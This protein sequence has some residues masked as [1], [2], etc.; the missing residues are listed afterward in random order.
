MSDNEFKPYIRHANY[1]ETD[2]M[3]IIHHSNYIRWMEEA[4]LDVMKQADISYKELE[5]MG[6][7]IPVLSVT[8]QYKNMV[9]FDDT[10]AITVKTIKYTGVKF[11]L[12]Y[13]FKD[14]E[15]DK[16]YTTG[17]SSH[18]FLDKNYR[19]FSLKRNYP[20]LHEKFERMLV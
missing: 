4:R 8:C 7:I 9:H 19:V 15:T 20:Q 10:V 12:E 13:E 1:Y 3:G 6:I 14:V 11:E 2:Q 18:C 5:E 16:L 17:T